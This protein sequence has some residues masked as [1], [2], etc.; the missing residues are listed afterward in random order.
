MLI[1]KVTIRQLLFL[2]VVLGL[3]FAVLAWAA[4][5]NV[6]AYSMAL[7]IALLI[8]PFAAYAAVYWTLLGIAKLRRMV[9][10]S[11]PTPSTESDTW[12]AA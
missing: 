2:M 8:I 12:E 3:Y 10:P 1:P 9:W 7:S 6:V 5:G 4:R 11:P